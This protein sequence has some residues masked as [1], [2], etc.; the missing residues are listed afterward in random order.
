MKTEYIEKKRGFSLVELLAVLTIV[1]IITVLT[2]PGIISLQESLQIGR[3]GTAVGDILNS[4]RQTALSCNRSVVARFY[5]PITKGPFTACQTFILQDDGSE[6]QL[7][8]MYTMPQNIVFSDDS[9]HSSIFGLGSS[10]A[11]LPDGSAMNCV[12]IR[13]RRNGSIDLDPSSFWFFTIA[14]AHEV[15]KAVPGN[16]LMFLIHPENG[17]IQTYRP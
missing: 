6:T 7:Q 3:A 8:R 9:N 10:V 16:Y 14:S 1:V 13:F 17:I 2:I 12:E 11:T 15:H 4:A 5:Q